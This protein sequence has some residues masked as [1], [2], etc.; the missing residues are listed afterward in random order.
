MTNVN[1]VFGNF[2]LPNSEMFMVL[3][4][5]YEPIKVGSDWKIK[6][7]TTYIDPVKFNQIFADA[8]I[9]AMNFWVQ[10]KCDM[11]VRRKMSSKVM[12]TL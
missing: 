5:R 1:K 2:A 6:D 10:V 9:D 8:S 11:K 3:T 7:L 4:R 12:P